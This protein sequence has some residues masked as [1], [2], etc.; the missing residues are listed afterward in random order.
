MEITINNKPVTTAATTL[1]G[2]AAEMDL[3]AKGIAIAINNKMI[4]RTEWEVTD[5]SEGTHL[6]MIKA[7]C[8]G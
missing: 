4:P 2:L 8:G 1:S 6:V 3:P 7:A 5:I